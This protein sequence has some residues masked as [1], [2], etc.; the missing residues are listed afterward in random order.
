MIQNYLKI[1][2]RNLLRYKTY[3]LINILGLAMGMAICVL[4]ILYVQHELSYDRYHE[5]S[6]LIYR[7]VHERDLNGTYEKIPRMPL[8]AKPVLDADFPEITHAVRFLR[9]FTPVVQHGDK[10]FIEDNFFFTDPEI[11]D[12]FSFELIQG[13]PET[14]LESDNSIVITEE[15]AR[16][17]FGDENPFGKNLTYRKWGQ[18]FDFAVTGVVKNLPD[19]SHFKFDFLAKMESSQNSWNAMHGQDWYYVGSWTYLLIPDKQAA[20]NLEQKL[21]GFV[22]RHFPEELQS[23]TTL[24][25]QPMTAIHLHSNMEQ[26][27]EANGNIFM[28]YVLG[29][30]AFAVLL[31][32]CINFMNL[33]TARS[34]TRA[35]EVGMRKVVGAFRGDL[36]RQFIGESLLMSVIAGIIAIGLVELLLPLFNMLVNQ[37]LVIDYFANPIILPALIFIVASVGILAGSYPAFYLSAFRPARVLKGNLNVGGG[38]P[39]LRKILVISQF[40]VSIALLI[41]I[42]IISQQVDFMRNKDLGFNKEEMAFVKFQPGVNFD[43]LKSALAQAPGVM[44]VVGGGSVPVS[45]NATPINWQMFRPVEQEDNMRLQMPSTVIDFDYAKTFGLELIDGR[46][47]SEDFSTD[48]NEAVLINETAAREFGWGTD[49]VGKEF[50]VY[51][52]IG[53]SAGVRRVVGVVRDYHFESLHQKIKPIILYTSNSRRYSNFI[54]R[55]NTE[56]LA[57]TLAFIEK[58]WKTAAPDFPLQLYFLNNDLNNLYQ[59][60]QQLN[61]IINYLTFL[62][63][64]ISCLGLFGLAAFSAEKRT[65]EIGVRKVLGASVINIIVMLS[66]EFT[67][68]VAVAFIVAVPLSYFLMDRWLQDFAYRINIGWEIFAI[69]GVLALLIALI[70]VSYQAIR[71]A[72]ANPVDALKYE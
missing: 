15:T 21:P 30:I 42:G 37:A 70:T 11:F 60:D 23:A 54:L 55:I 71:A 69:A 46:F 10:Q 43:E 41:A 9:E 22:Q 18:Q 13:N 24:T 56:N 62:A 40:V 16:K 53:A 31:I 50:E 58:E 35:R 4:I 51:N 12:V 8:A 44:E 33:A 28:I 52:M 3:S 63:I 20:A 5:N 39:A 1:A 32:A 47:F 6:D 49:A 29:A 7:L 65:K 68:L 36:I 14:A 26:E 38:A 48:P 67:R 19:N 27:L 64:F 34:A 57:G 45:E 17:Y 25:L 2:L 72:L 61:L 59:R 66:K